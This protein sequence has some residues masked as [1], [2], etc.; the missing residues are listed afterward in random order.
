MQGLHPPPPSRHR[1]LRCAS[2]QA[3]IMV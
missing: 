1:L 3:V 2:C